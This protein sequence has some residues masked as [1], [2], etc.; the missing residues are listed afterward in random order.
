MYRGFLKLSDKSKEIR[1]DSD[2]S[3]VLFRATFTAPTMANLGTTGIMQAEALLSYFNT[4][5][6]TSRIVVERWTGGDKLQIVPDAKLVDIAEICGNKKGNVTIKSANPASATHTT[7]TAEF[8]LDLAA[9]GTIP[10]RNGDYIRIAITETA[11]YND[12]LGGGAGSADATIKLF[13]YTNYQRRN[14]H[15]KY[16]I[17][18]VQKDAP[19]QFELKPNHAIIMIPANVTKL[20]LKGPDADLDLTAEELT[21]IASAESDTVFLVNGLSLIQN[22]WR[23]FSLKGFTRG[24]ITLPADGNFY[25]IGYE[26]FER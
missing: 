19:R 16:D 26:D 24:D 15:M 3:K 18:A 5:L 23:A 4:M 2:A 1:I 7:Y 8:S 17:I 9:Q 6:G 22:N 21:G 13:T 20:N 11:M 25:F 12:G 10:V 14:N